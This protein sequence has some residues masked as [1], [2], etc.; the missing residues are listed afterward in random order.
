M[1]RS[2]RFHSLY[3]LLYS[4]R[5]KHFSYIYEEYKILCVPLTWMIHSEFVIRKVSLHSVSEGKYTFKESKV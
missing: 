4:N 3:F 2:P 1:Q 5:L